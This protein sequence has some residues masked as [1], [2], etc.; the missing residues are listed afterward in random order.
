M[1]ASLT[2]N[3]GNQMFRV[4]I[5]QLKVMAQARTPVQ[6]SLVPNNNDPLS[7]HYITVKGAFDT[8]T[9]ATGILV[10]KRDEIKLYKNLNRAVAEIERIFPTLNE[11]TVLTV[12]GSSG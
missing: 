4:T 2:A 12:H 1:L 11:V 7:G 8:D 9:G 10:T 6:I 5:N 3:W